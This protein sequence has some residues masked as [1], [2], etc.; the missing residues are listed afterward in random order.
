MIDLGQSIAEI[1]ECS[2]EDVDDVPEESYTIVDIIVNSDDHN[3]LEAA[4]IE[5]NLAT[6]LS[7]DGPFT[8][9]APTDAAFDALPAGTVETLLQDPSGQLTN[10]LLHHVVSGETLSTD[11]SDG[12]MIE[13]LNE[14]NV[15]VTIQSDMVMIDNAVVTF[16]DLIADNGVVHVIDAVLIPSEN[17]NITENTYND[18]IILT[19]DLNGKIVSKSVKNTILLDIYESGKIYKRIRK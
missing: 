4:V 3:T 9:F 19:V 15:N 16:A 6:T 11:L 12:M 13:T 14:S 17:S 7:G 5:A 8:V 10:I 18:N 2:C 1:C